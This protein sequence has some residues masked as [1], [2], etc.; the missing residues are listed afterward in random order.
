MFKNYLD[1]LT[2]FTPNYTI[3]KIYLKVR[4]QPTINHFVN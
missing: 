1:A 3:F 4:S 2:F